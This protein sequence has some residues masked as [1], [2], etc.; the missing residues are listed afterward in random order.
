[1][2][3]KEFIESF[4]D[5]KERALIEQFVLNEQMKQA[6]KKVLLSGI[7]QSGVLKKG[8]PADT[9]INF[10]MTIACQK[11]TN[12]E[13]IGRDVKSCWEGINA[14][15]LGFEDLELFRPVKAPDVKQNPAR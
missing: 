6:V 14:L 12:Y 5:D 11:G 15:E 10:A 1:M 3:K 13:Q 8:K 9:S 7:Y 2:S 4:V